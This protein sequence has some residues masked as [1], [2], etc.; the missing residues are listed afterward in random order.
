[1]VGFVLL[2]LFVVFGL[3]FG[4]AWLVTPFVERVARRSGFMDR[5]HPRRDAILKPRLGGVAMY[6]AFGVAL[7]ATVPLVARDAAEAQK[8]VGILLG[9]AIVLTMGAADD[10]FDLPAL[11]QLAAQVLAA[12]VAMA[13]GVVIT[14][15]T[16]PFGDDLTNSMILLPSGAAFAFTAFWIVG[17]VNTVNFLDGVDGLAV[18]VGAV[19]AAVLGLH[20]LLIG[21]YSIAALAAALAGSCLGF[22]PH[23]FFPA[24][25]TMGSSGAAFLGFA[26]ATL[27]IVGGAKTATLL[28]VLGVPIADTGWA[29]VRRLAAGRSPFIGD[30]GH[31]HHMLLDLGWQPSQIVLLVYG[32]CGSF[33]MLALL[34]SSRLQKL[35]AIG[36][37]AVL[38]AVGLA[39]LAQARGRARRNTADNSPIKKS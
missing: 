16:N 34:L 38:L 32:A 10:R 2:P 1:M 37:L 28:L 5:P 11:P 14:A 23:N 4:V 19:A 29:I 3:A 24:R 22:L 25:I 31:L 36:G 27:A 7:V 39:F 12:I 30:R 15:V 33:G 17:A 21:Q 18:G 20:S 35:I 26:L 8:V 9:G 13:A 6:A